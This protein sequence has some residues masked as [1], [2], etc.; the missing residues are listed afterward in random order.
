MTL[1][2]WL[3]DINFYKG[4]GRRLDEGVISRECA[5]GLKH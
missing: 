4:H 3:L 2:D 1:G 5:V